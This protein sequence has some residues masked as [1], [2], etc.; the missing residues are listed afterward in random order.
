MTY[1]FVTYDVDD[2]VPAV[3]TI[4][5][6]NGHSLSFRSP[7]KYFLFRTDFYLSFEVTHNLIHRQK[8]LSLKVV[9]IIGRK[10]VTHI[11]N[12]V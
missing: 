12:I 9:I 1:F 3:R 7:V 8:I 11:L 10:K 2:R 5:V 6:E 4:V